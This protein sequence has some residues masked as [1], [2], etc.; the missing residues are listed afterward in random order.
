MLLNTLYNYWKETY[1]NR[2]KPKFYSKLGCI[3]SS[4][5]G[6]GGIYLSSGPILMGGII[7]IT[8]SGCYL[9]W[10]YLTEKT[11]TDADDYNLIINKLNE[12]REIIHERLTIPSAPVETSYYYYDYSQT[13]DNI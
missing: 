13:A 4:L 8:V 1:I 3:S 6:F 12:I 2:T 10:K 7:G 9:F 5:S 11:T